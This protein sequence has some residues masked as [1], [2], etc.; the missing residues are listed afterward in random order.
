MKGWIATEEYDRIIWNYLA[1]LLREFLVYKIF[2]LTFVPLF[3]DILK[4]L[5]QTGLEIYEL[6]L[7]VKF[8]LSDLMRQDFNKR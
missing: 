1:F 5:E 4:S 8:L 7:V 2:C 3:F 6:S